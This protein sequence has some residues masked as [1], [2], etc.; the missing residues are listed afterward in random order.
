MLVYHKL[1]HRQEISMCQINI[2]VL[3]IKPMHKVVGNP[4]YLASGFQFTPPLE[5]LDITYY[6]KNPAIVRVTS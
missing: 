2:A 4:G 3:S 6:K 1:T 5:I